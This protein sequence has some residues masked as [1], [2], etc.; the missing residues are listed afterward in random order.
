MFLNSFRYF[1]SDNFGLIVGLGIGIPLF[2]VLIAFLVYVYIYTR[3]PNLKD[4]EA[5][6]YER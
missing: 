1:F 5:D 6:E 3:K 4:H 2:F